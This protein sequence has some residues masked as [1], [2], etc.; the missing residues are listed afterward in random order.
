VATVPL[1]LGLGAALF[2]PR[3]LVSE[4]L[5]GQVN[6]LLFVAGLL[7]CLRLGRRILGHQGIVAA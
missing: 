3:A 6:T 4:S 1:I 2:E 7:W 5:P